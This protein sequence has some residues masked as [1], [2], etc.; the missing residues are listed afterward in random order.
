M[1]Y[2]NRNNDA[3]GRKEHVCRLGPVRKTSVFSEKIENQELI[4]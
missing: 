4:L 3:K 1:S 2:W